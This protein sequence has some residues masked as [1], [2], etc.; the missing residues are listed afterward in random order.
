MYDHFQILM[1]AYNAT[2]V[3][4]CQ[5]SYV[6]DQRKRRNEHECMLTE[7]GSIDSVEHISTLVSARPALCY[8]VVRCI[9]NF[10]NADLRSYTSLSRRKN[11]DPGQIEPGVRGP[12]SSDR[13][14]GKRLY[15]ENG[16]RHIS[17]AVAADYASTSLSPM[18][19]MSSHHT[20][21]PG[22]LIQPCI[23]SSHTISQR[24][25]TSTSF[26]RSSSSPPT[27]VVFSPRTTRGIR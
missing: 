16:T 5:V 24:F 20:S 26:D 11:M 23:I 15:L 2:L 12:S 10:T 7:K 13:D 1:E 14:G 21:F 8:V 22:P 4:S 25:T 27:N 9:S 19:P 18:S 3:P 17:R 6:L